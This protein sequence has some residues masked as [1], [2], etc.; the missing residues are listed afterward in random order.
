MFIKEWTVE[1]KLRKDSELWTNWL[2]KYINRLYEEE[3]SI[4]KRI[5]L[6]NSTNPRFILRNHLAQDSIEHAEQGDFERAKIFLK[7]LENPFSID[8][9]ENILTDF[10]SSECIFKILK[11]C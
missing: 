5:D 10:K 8:S 3:N 2:K 1:D 4:D 9:I 11:I 6:M 7:I